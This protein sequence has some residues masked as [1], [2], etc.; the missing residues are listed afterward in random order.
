MLFVV[1]LACG[2]AAIVVTLRGLCGSTIATGLVPVVTLAY[3]ALFLVPIANE[4]ASTRPLVRALVTQGVAP[5]ETALYVCPHV[6]V[7][8]MD[9]SLSNVH[10]VDANELRELSPRLIVVRRKD[11]ET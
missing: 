2:V 4:M 6:W 9:P 5:E 3:T 7:R 8:G 11:A 10:Y 1:L